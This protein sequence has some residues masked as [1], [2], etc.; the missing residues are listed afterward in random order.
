[1]LLGQFA[2]QASLIHTFHTYTHTGVLRE[3]LVSS[4]LWEKLGGEIFRDM[5]VDEIVTQL[6]AEQGIKPLPSSSGWASPNSVNRYT[7]VPSRSHQPS[8]SGRGIIPQAQPIREEA[9]IEEMEKNGYGSTVIRAPGPAN[10][11][12]REAGDAGPGS[13]L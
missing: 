4:K 2:P 12:T 10:N 1:M 8:N 5:S 7:V 6:L 9:L 3:R 13:S 11:G